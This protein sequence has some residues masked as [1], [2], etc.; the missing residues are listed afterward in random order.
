[1]Q[2]PCRAEATSDVLVLSDEPD[3]ARRARAFARRRLSVAAALLTDVELAVSELVSNAML[4]GAPP[5]EVRVLPLGDGARVEVADQSQRRLVMPVPSSD[6]MTGRG[7]ALVA[8]LSSRWGVEPVQGG[9]K[10]V[11]A[12]LSPE[13]ADTQDAPDV[14]LDAFLAAWA[15]DEPA[16]PEY[17]VRLGAVPTDL[18]LDAKRHI[19]NIVREL[20]FESAAEAHGPDL[21][22]EFRLL[23]ETVTGSFSRART[24]IKEQAAAAATR[25]DR[26]TELVLTLPAWS[27]AAGEDYLVALDEADRYSRSARLLTLET[28]PLHRLFRRWYVTALIEQLRSLSVGQQPVQPTPFLEVLASEVASLT[29]SRGDLSADATAQPGAA[30]AQ[31]WVGGHQERQLVNLADAARAIAGATSVE[32][33]LEVVTEAADRK[34]VV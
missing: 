5:V 19:D 23:I 17:T 21:P 1:M 11:W 20:H 13:T 25:G 29:A 7:L 27:V 26:Q 9:G 28:P 24:S 3:G 31:V 33:L 14:D 4:H 22:A 8:A 12:E 2:T 16:E 34:S 15:D 10:V 6:A 30:Q 32:E 18:L